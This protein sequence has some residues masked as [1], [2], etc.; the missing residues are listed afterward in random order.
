MLIADGELPRN[1]RPR[2]WESAGFGARSYRRKSSAESASFRTS[3]VRV[4]EN[5]PE[6]A[7]HGLHNQNG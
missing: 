6:K 5:F 2:A 7:E 3:E 1:H 4:G